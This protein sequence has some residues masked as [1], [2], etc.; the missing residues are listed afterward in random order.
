MSLLP[1]P[2]DDPF[3]ERD[4]LFPGRAVGF[5]CQRDKL[6]GVW[7]YEVAFHAQGTNKFGN[8]VVLALSQIARFR[9]RQ[10]FNLEI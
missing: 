3:E 7:L 6:L 1:P 5:H 9:Q 4:E 10:P 8:F 2:T